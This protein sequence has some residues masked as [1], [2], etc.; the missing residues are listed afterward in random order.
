MEAAQQSAVGLVS[1]ERGNA[2]LS[3]SGTRPGRLAAPQVV[4]ELHRQR[5]IPLSRSDV[6]DVFAG[7]RWS[8][9]AIGSLPRFFAV[10]RLIRRPLDIGRVWWFA[11]L[12]CF[13][14]IR[15]R[16]LE[17]HI[18]L[19]HLSQ[20]APS[21]LGKQAHAVAEPL[22]MILVEPTSNAGICFSMR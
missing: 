22:L 21:S 17:R 20:V 5:A 6:L 12:L 2:A 18:D 15:P 11:G 16:C 13:V 9:R 14:G 19:K 3:V 1:T 4:T 8:S 10:V 7:E